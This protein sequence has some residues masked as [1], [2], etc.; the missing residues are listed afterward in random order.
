MKEIRHDFKHLLALAVLLIAGTVS[1]WA[2]DEFITTGDQSGDLPLIGMQ[3]GSYQKCEFVIPAS[4]LEKIK[5]KSIK[6]LKFPIQHTSMRAYFGNCVVFMK[7]VDFTVFSKAKGFTGYADA[8]V[9]YEGGLDATGDYM[10][11]PIEEGTTYSYDK[12]NLLIGIYITS[13]TTVGENGELQAAGGSV[14]FMG[15]EADYVTGLACYSDYKSNVESNTWEVNF[16]P[17]LVMDVVKMNHKLAGNE[18]HGT[19]VFTVDGK[20]VTEA[21]EEDDVTLTVTADEGYVAA[22][23][24]KTGTKPADLTLTA[25]ST[26]GTYTFEMAAVN[27]YIDCDYLRNIGYAVEARGPKVV[28]WTGSPLDPDFKLVDVIDPNNEKNLIKGTDYTVAYKK[29][30]DNSPV[31]PLIDVGAYIAV[32]T[33]I[34]NYTGTFNLDFTVQKKIQVAL[35]AHYMGTYFFDN[36]IETFEADDNTG[37]E[38]GTVTAVA[39]SG[40]AT[41]TPITNSKIAKQY[42]FLV[43]NN[44]NEPKTF[45]LWETI[46][47]VTV[48][49][50]TPATQ[51]KGTA[52]DQQFSVS[53]TKDYY[54]LQ[55]IETGDVSVT[56]EFVYVIGEGT[57]KAHR[58]WIELPKA[59]GSRILT[60]TLDETTGISDVK[61]AAIADGIYD[62]QGRRL[63]GKPSQRGLYVIDGKKVVVK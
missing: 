41:I 46:S 14:R 45:T 61:A 50:P 22:N 5:G 60:I 3:A 26:A 12:G 39:A 8:T 28:E 29:K 9:I 6:T 4:Y 54:V 10:E 59:A 47:D 37:M 13:L 24:G 11:I 34:G 17:S 21:A 25:G 16:L 55:N 58:C 18:D 1:T 19:M 23:V 27:V 30:S 43:Y 7:E 36:A 2:A 35:K 63:T 52:A 57:K 32:V 44:S 53:E 42:P 62:M 38:L 56:H 49:N 15:S 20:T 51:F 31:D 33:G 40:K 48:S